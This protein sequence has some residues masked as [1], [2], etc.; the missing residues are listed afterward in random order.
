MIKLDLM[1]DEPL[2]NIVAEMFSGLLPHENYEPKYFSQIL[3]IIF[4]YMEFEEFKMEFRCLAYIFLEV[5]KTQ[6]MSVDFKPRL[7][8]DWVL[9]T[10]E[11]KMLDFV[12]QE[13]TGVLEWNSQNGH[14]TDLKN[15]LEVTASAERLYGRINDLYDKAFD[16]AI[17]SEEC[18]SRDLSLKE[19][20]LGNIAQTSVVTMAQILEDSSQIG[21]KVYIGS[22]GWA[23][24]LSQLSLTVNERFTNK[25]ENKAWKLDSLEALKEINDGME[26]LF[27]DLASWGIKVLDDGVRLLKHWLLVICANENVGKTALLV[28]ITVLM[29]R[30]KQPVVYMCGESVK[31]II[32]ARILSNYIRA[33]RKY[34][35]TS[36]EISKRN[37]K[38][39]DGR[40]VVSDEKRKVIEI[41]ELELVESKL[42]RYVHALSY[43]KF[44]E[45]CKELYEDSPFAC[46]LVD[47]SRALT[48]EKTMYEDIGALS[49]QGRN[50]KNDF[51]VLLII[52]S[53]LS[54]V[55][56]DLLAKGKKVDTSPTKGNS[57]LSAEADQ[58]CIL[59]R[60]QKMKERGLVGLDVTKTRT[61]FFLSEY[62]IL[63]A[64]SKVSHFTYNPDDQEEFSASAVEQ[65]NMIQLISDPD[66]DEEDDGGV[67]RTMSGAT[68]S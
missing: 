33:T 58:V 55:A 63:R 57:T 59:F 18:L 46:M 51:P 7:T 12:R 21:R 62:V 39:P 24:Y 61:D 64:E 35:I 42:I 8:K 49:I 52:A 32:H 54:T 14:S 13:G 66:E 30:F 56:K 34:F 37:A 23:N 68:I 65:E 20:V 36:E 6:V 28:H 44:Y 11:N 4:R 25:E 19:S 43:Y 16:L 53:H 29:V 45:Q 48:D 17:P 41:S 22:E 15:E 60:D 27:T 10:L 9:A 38:T 3:S 50:F 40:P 26:Q 47:H 5:R 2:Q 1:S 31:E 67:W